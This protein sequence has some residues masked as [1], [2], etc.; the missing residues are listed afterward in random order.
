MVNERRLCRRLRTGPRSKRDAP[1]PLANQRTRRRFRRSCCKNCIDALR[2]GVPNE[3]CG[4]LVFGPLL[5]RGRGR[6]T[7]DFAAQRGRHRRIA[8]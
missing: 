4:I 8:I 3:A 1:R 5:G 6:P 2:A 7:V